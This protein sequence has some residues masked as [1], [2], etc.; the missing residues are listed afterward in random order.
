MLLKAPPPE[1]GDDDVSI[2]E[3]AMDKHDVLTNLRSAETSAFWLLWESNR[4]DLL[5]V[6]NYWMNNAFDAEDALSAA[7]LRAF[8]G[9][10]QH[11]D[12]IVSPKGWL[13]RLTRNICIDMHKDEQKQENIRFRIGEQ[14]TYPAASPAYEPEAIEDETEKPIVLRD[15]I[16]DLDPRYRLP[17][18]LRCLRKMSYRNIATALNLTEVNVRKRV[19]LARKVL[20][21]RCGQKEI[22]ISADDFGQTDV[23]ESALA[24]RAEVEMPVGFVHSTSVSIQGGVELSV[25]LVVKRRVTHVKLQLNSIRRYIGRHPGGWKRRLELADLLYAIGD[26]DAAFTEYDGLLEQRRLPSVAVRYVHMLRVMGRDVSDAD[27]LKMLRHMQHD[28]GRL[29]LRAVLCFCRRNFPE[30]RRIFEKAIEV[31]PGNPVHWFELSRVC[32]DTKSALHAIRGAYVLLPG[33]SRILHRFFY[34]LLEAGL[35]SEAFCLE[36][37]P[38]SQDILIVEL[39]VEK[40]LLMRPRLKEEIR[41]ARALIQRL[42]RHDPTSCVFHD[43]YSRIE[44]AYGADG[45]KILNGFVQKYPLNP[46]GHYNCALRLAACDDFSGAREAIERARQLRGDDIAINRAYDRIFSKSSLGVALEYRAHS[47]CIV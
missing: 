27:G 38:G 33:D 34:L 17:L 2:L 26:W 16:Q 5:R 3:T 30:A 15:V 20:R 25:C 8:D 4:K 37:Q 44:T 7:M 28:A 29:H 14:P 32:T 31:E 10:R 36:S 40:I 19:Q 42:L 21:D 23:V 13:M 47:V 41:R 6:C 9:Y 45:M 39:L 43:L 18:E 1:E 11:A 22:S 12:R 35:E 24:R 46:Y